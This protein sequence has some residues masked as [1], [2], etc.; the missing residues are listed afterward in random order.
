MSLESIL[1]INKSGGLIYNRNFN[2]HADKNI[3]SND[4]LILA[5]TLHSAFTLTNCILPEVLTKYSESYND[6]KN[7]DENE[8]ELNINDEEC[9][10]LPVQVKYYPIGNKNNIT[11]N[12]AIA[13]NLLKETTML[14]TDLFHNKNDIIDYQQVS[15]IRHIDTNDLDIYFYQTIT[16]L[17]IISICN[18]SKNL[19][20]DRMTCFMMRIHSLLSDYVLKNP[21]YSVDMPIRKN[22]LFEDKVEMLVRMESLIDGPLS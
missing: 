19:E 8:Q 6:P 1:I 15:C 3:N 13:N 14:G 9:L 18:K 22:N 12:N 2:S 16:G 17:K 11:S 7:T 5:S 21:F 10:R 20:V 4:M